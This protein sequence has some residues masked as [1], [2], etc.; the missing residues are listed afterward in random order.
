LKL[1]PIRWDYLAKFHSFWY[2]SVAMCAN[3][4]FMNIDIDVIEEVAS[5]KLF[6]SNISF[7]EDFDVLI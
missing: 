4:V 6:L 5:F 3:G 2:C 7:L 1:V